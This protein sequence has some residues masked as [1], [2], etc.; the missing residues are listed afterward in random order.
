MGSCWNDEKLTAFDHLQPW[1]AMRLNT[2]NSNILPQGSIDCAMGG[3]IARTA[4]RRINFSN[5]HSIVRNG[6]AR[7]RPVQ[8]ACG[9]VENG[10]LSRNLLKLN[11]IDAN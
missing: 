2:N 4:E 10:C 3:R 1:L 8:L 7:A 9:S 5:I 11:L 6:G